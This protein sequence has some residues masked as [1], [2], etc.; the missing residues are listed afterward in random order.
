[1]KRLFVIL[2]AIVLLSTGGLGGAAM[3]GYGPLA[4]LFGTDKK[5]EEPPPPPPPKLRVITLGTFIIP[6]IENHTIAR[7]IGM[8]VDLRVDPAQND[9]VTGELTRLHNAYLLRL[10]EVVPRHSDPRSAFDRQ[11]IHDELMR[12][13]DDVCGEGAVRE[14]VIKSIY[15]R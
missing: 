11:V 12:I 14:V 2:L 8:D 3:F 13:S 1:M 9:K 10:Y 6:V 15:G 5:K 4:P 7:Q